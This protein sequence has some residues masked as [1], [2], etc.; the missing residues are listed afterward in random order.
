MVLNGREVLQEG[1]PY[2]LQVIVLGKQADAQAP[3]LRYRTMGK[4]RY[5]A[6]PMQAESSNIYSV[7]VPEHGGK[8]IEYDVVFVQNGHEYH[9]P[10][11]APALGG[12]WVWLKRNR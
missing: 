2:R 7:T 8:T 5:K 3:V 4:G 12:V 11:A 1:E 6:L 9:Y 10:E